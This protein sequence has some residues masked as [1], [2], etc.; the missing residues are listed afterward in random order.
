MVVRL[1]KSTLAVYRDDVAGS[2]VTVNFALP[3][4]LS[5]QDL[6]IHIP[7]HAEGRRVYFRAPPS[8]PPEGWSMTATSTYADASAQQAAA[9]VP[10][11]TSA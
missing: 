9:S 10:C 2:S 4:Q 1:G 5:L 8:C 6:R 3:P 11:R 7:V